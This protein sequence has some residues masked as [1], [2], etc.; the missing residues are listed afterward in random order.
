MISPYVQKWF[1]LR[2]WIFTSPYDKSPV[3]AL[4]NNSEIADIQRSSG[5]ACSC[6]GA[7]ALS[8]NHIINEILSCRYYPELAIPTTTIVDAFVQYSMIKLV[9]P[10]CPFHCSLNSFQNRFILFCPMVFQ[11]INVLRYMNN[12][13]IRNF[14]SSYF[15][16]IIHSW[17]DILGKH[18]LFLQAKATHGTSVT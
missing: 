17:I 9:R 10:A 18:N 15:Q 1:H 11:G 5:S 6:P 3:S 7:C 13:S 4:I 16:I 8:L 12:I 2:H 14:F